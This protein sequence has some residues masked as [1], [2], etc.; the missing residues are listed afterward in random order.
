MTDRI[1]ITG[2][3]GYLGGRVSKYLSET[4][5]YELR[6]TTR[7]N[8]N[9]CPVWLKN[10]EIIKLDFVSDN[11]FSLLCE[12]VKCVIHLAAMN[13]IDCASDP[14]SALAVNGLGSLKFLN[15]ALKAG[16]KRFIYFSTAHIYGSPLQGI[17][18]EKSCPR[19]VHPYAIS[20]RTAEDFV[21]SAHD[22]KAIVGIV[23]RLSNGLGCPVSSDINRWTLLVNDLCR[24]AATTGKLILKS[25]GIQ[26]RDFIA[27]T[28]VCRA[29]SHLLTLPAERCLDGLFNLG[30]ECSMS[31]NEMAGLIADRCNKVLGFMPE[32]VMLKTKDNNISMP[33][34]YSIDKIKSTGFELNR[35]I[36]EEIDSELKFCKDKFCANLL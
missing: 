5:D 17:I 22:K 28:D 16:V 4:T 29:V 27:L 13:E 32:I 25:S 30:G 18:N 36:I 15:A 6:I 14:V 23:L 8:P 1:L 2:G 19:P 9:D 3:L 24:Q 12:G 34:E 11:D 20:H 35:N 26:K 33:L 7:K 31:I 10:G 21:L